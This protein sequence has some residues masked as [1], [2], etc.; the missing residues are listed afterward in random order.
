MT[1]GCGGKGGAERAGL[2][3]LSLS[4]SSSVSV[5]SLICTLCRWGPVAFYR[6]EVLEFVT[7]MEVSCLYE[8]LFAF[9]GVHFAS[10]ESLSPEVHG[11]D[12]VLSNCAGMCG[13]TESAHATACVSVGE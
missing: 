12:V 10:F 2:K 8:S 5:V 1:R 4:P 6:A 13:T 11:A 7:R 3:S 9:I